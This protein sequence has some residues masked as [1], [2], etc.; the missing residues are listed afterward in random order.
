[1]T[2]D[3]SRKKQLGFSTTQFN[4]SSRAA[5]RRTDLRIDPQSELIRL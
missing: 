5:R 2:D 3:R 1:M 4:H